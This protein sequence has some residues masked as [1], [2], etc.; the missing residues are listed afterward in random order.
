MAPPTT[1]CV[2]DVNE[3]SGA[4]YRGRLRALSSGWRAGRVTFVVL[5]VT[6]AVT[7]VA[8]RAPTVVTRAVGLLVTAVEVTTSPERLR[9]VVEST[10]PFAPLT[11]ISLHGFQVFFA[12]LPGQVT[13]LTAGYVFGAVEGTVYAVIGLC[14]GSVVAL[15]A[16]RHYGRPVTE[17]FVSD[18]TMARFDEVSTRHGLTPFAVAFLLPGFPDDALVFLAGLTELKFWRLLAVSVVARVPTLVALTVSGD[19]LATA[20]LD[21]FV[22]VAGLTLLVTLAA[23]Q[24]RDRILPAG[25]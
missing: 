19:S 22:T 18:A 6:L 20:N 24:F 2:T 13:G 8:W 16:S 23:W 7:V 10:G 9:V 25:V 21:L 15:A 1:L 11:L 3:R 14:L 12:P 5:L 4:E 17:R